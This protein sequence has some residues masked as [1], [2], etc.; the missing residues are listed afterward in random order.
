M[1]ALSLGVPILAVPQLPEHILV[2]DRV[3]ELSLG[4]KITCDISAEELRAAALGL[5]ADAPTAQALEQMREYIKK[6][7]GAPRAVDEIESYMLRV[8]GKDRL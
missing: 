7:G 1:E 3:A 4:R 6:A 2:A 5:A 8:G